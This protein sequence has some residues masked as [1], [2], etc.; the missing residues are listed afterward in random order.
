MPE[1]ILLHDGPIGR[2]RI[3]HPERRNAMT[4]E[5]WEAL[6]SALEGLEADPSVRVIV[7]E[8]EG[9]QAFIA[10]ADISQFEAQRTDPAAQARYDAA[11]DAAYAAPGRFTKPVVACIR[12][13]C[14]GGG[15]GL[16]AACDL[17]FCSSDARFRMPAAR[18]GIGY[19]LAGLERFLEVIGLQNT[20]DVFLSARIFDAQEAQRMGFVARVCAPEALAAEVDDWCA[21]VAA[22]APLTLRATKQ[23]TSA[24]ARSSGPEQR[25]AA[26]AAIAACAQSE[27]YREGARAFL[28]KRAPQF[29]GC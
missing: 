22:N 21:M 8:G 11:V 5:M 2:V 14:M 25:E 23:A 6:P 29:K 19:G 9:D 17:R 16:A 15:L 12:G 1:L 4:L 20:L 13:I 24:L 7:I 10:G 27:D 26:L 28:E 3:S 18:L